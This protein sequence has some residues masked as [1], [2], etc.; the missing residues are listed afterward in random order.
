M[1]KLHEVI[2]NTKAMVSTLLQKVKNNTF[3][4][5]LAIMY[6]V[7]HMRQTLSVI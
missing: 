5:T 7:C 1:K 6:I 3:W 4:F 2:F